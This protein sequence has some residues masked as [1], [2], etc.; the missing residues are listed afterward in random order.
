MTV[1]PLEVPLILQTDA[2]PLMPVRWD[3]APEQVRAHLQT[4]LDALAKRKPLVDARWRYYLGQHDELWMTQ[5]LREVFGGKSPKLD[6]NYCE[7]AVEAVVLRLAV[8]G[9]TARRPER[10][11]EAE[12]ERIVAEVTAQVEAN[13]LD[14]EAEEV[15]RAA[16]V[17][18]EHYLMVWPRYANP[19]DPTDLTQEEDEDGVPLF[20][21]TEQDARNVYSQQRAGGRVK[22]WKVKVWLDAPA[23]RWRAT[24]YYADQVVRLQTVQGSNGTEP[25]KAVRFDLDPDDP[26]GPNPMGK[27]PF[28]RFAKDKRGR[29]RLDALSPVQ[30]KINKWS[31]GKMVAGEFA[32]L[33]QRYILSD[34]VIPDGSLRSVPGNVWTISGDGGADESESYPT[35]VGEF[36]AADLAQL[37]GSKREEVD[38]FLTLGMLPRNLRAGGNQE[39]SGEAITKD[40]GPFVS[41]VEDHQQ[42]YGA[43]WRDLWQLCGYDVIPDWEPAEFANAKLLAEE[44]K[45]YRDAG[46]PLAVALEHVGWSGDEVQA[47]LDALDDETDRNT[48]ASARALLQLDQGDAIALER[49]RGAAGVGAATPGEPL[50]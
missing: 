43:A 25:P 9:W 41:M 28:V 50:P 11:A 35:K 47:A 39:R 8:K 10:V 32:A 17:A 33:R 49:L 23:K 34:Q 16:G 2:A 29:S 31:V 4:A 21:I 26:G 48:T 14:I 1:M 15:H 46:V 13:G 30:D 38:T 27:P 20:D 22:D 7:L 44:V 19:D 3:S 45:L 12:A 40:N 5:K 6:D 37:D 42:M 36:S 18:G 24:F